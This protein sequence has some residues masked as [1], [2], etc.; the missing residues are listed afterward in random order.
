[1]RFEWEPLAVHA[2]ADLV[3]YQSVLGEQIDDHTLCG[4]EYIMLNPIYARTHDKIVFHDH[5]RILVS[6]GGAD[7]RSL[8]GEV[9][10]RLVRA[11]PL[12][13]YA[14]DAVIG[15]ATPKPVI[16]P[17]NVRAIHAP[18]TLAFNIATSGMA[19]MSMG[20]SAYEAACLGVP[21]AL[22]S[23]TDDHEKTAIELERR[24]VAVNLGRWDRVDWQKMG[25]FV[26]AMSNPDKFDAW[27]LMSK[28]GKEL[29]DGMGV[30][31]VADR[32]EALL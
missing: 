14:I 3:V 22:I 15:P 29:I 30:G 19:I 5:A 17:A 2:L 13:M 26:G 8:T 9:C 20:M 11:L 12:N 25:E 4:A 7:I 21:T 1:M 10:G 31:R 27:I 6:M 32:I 23:W 28:S 24:G 18:N 16:L